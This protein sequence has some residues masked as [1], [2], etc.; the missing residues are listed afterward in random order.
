MIFRLNNNRKHLSYDE[1]SPVT[2]RNLKAVIFT[3]SAGSMQ[4]SLSKTSYLSPIFHSSWHFLLLQNYSSENRSKR[5]HQKQQSMSKLLK[6]CFCCTRLKWEMTETGWYSL[7]QPTEGEIINVERSFSRKD[8][9]YPILFTRFF[10]FSW[11]LSAFAA[12]IIRYPIENRFIFIGYFSHWV[13]ATTLFYQFLVLLISIFRDLITGILRQPPEGD[14][15]SYIIRMVWGLYSVCV[16]TSILLNFHLYS[17]D[18]KMDYYHANISM[19]HN[20]FLHTIISVMIL[21][22]GAILSRVPVKLKHYLFVFLYLFSFFMWSIIHDFSPVGNGT[23]PGERSFQDTGDNNMT[24]LR[25]LNE[26]V[27]NETEDINDGIDD[28]NRIGLRDD[29]ALYPFVSWK[30]MPGKTS[31]FFFVEMFIVAPICFFVIWLIS[32]KPRPIYGGPLGGL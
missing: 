12:H 6:F 24:T 3:L 4:D 31:V 2:I 21:I 10:F 14:P 23:W 18:L 13:W 22:D 8:Y 9:A 32:L 28:M 26:T 15:P 30:A 29:D 11:S 19:Y 27:F 17:P 25:M 20:V 16:V 7:E 5:H 1:Q